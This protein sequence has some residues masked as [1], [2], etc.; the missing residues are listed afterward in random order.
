MYD[1]ELTDYIKLG[2]K[3]KNISIEALEMVKELSS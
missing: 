1:L 2:V 3:L